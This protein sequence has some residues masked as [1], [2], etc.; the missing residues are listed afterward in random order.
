MPLPNEIK[1]ELFI[2]LVVIQA[3]VKVNIYKFVKI[4]QV[5]TN[6]ADFN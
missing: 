5:T 2:T 6:D 1:N 3:P 4:F